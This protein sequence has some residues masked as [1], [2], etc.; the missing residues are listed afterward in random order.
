MWRRRKAFVL[1][2]QA[3]AAEALQSVDFMA[4]AQEV[5]FE[6]P[7]ALFDAY[8]GAVARECAEATIPGLG[9]SGWAEPTSSPRG[10]APSRPR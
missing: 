5:G 1:D 4:I 9:R 10:T 7:W 8:L 3:N 6:N 2:L